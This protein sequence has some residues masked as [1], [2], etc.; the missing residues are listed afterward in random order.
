MSRFNPV[1]EIV[2]TT[3]GLGTLGV[4]GVLNFPLLL[5]GLGAIGIYTGTKLL[6]SSSSSPEKIHINPELPQDIKDK[7]TKYNKVLDSISR[8]KSLVENKEILERL[9]KVEDYGRKIIGVLQDNEDTYNKIEE[10]LK[11]F[12]SVEEILGKYIEISSHRIEYDRKDKTLQNFSTLLDEILISLKDYYKRGLKGE[13]L[14]LDVDMKI[15]KNKV[16]STRSVVG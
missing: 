10:V 8:N 2:S 13:L 14:E 3:A 16:K 11:I 15:L 12:Q 1:K 9:T 6:M 7:V 5:S 4:L